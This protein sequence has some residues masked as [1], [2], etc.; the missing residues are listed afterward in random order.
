[1]ACDMFTVVGVKR[2]R[3]SEKMKKEING[4]DKYVL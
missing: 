1:V 4:R 3:E 2:E